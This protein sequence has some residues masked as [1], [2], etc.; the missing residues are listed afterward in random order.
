MPNKHVTAT[1]PS[2][3]PLG[4]CH[5]LRLPRELRNSI[6]HE[7]WKHTPLVDATVKQDLSLVLLYQTKWD[8][9]TEFQAPPA[10]LRTSKMYLSEGLEELHSGS[11]W[12]LR[13]NFSRRSFRFSYRIP[14]NTALLGPS[15]S[16]TLVIRTGLVGAQSSRTPHIFEMTRGNKARIGSALQTPRLVDKLHT[17]RVEIS[18]SDMRRGIRWTAKQLG[19]MRECLDL[20]VLAQSE[21]HLHHFEIQLTNFNDLKRLNIEPGSLNSSLHLEEL[22]ADE[23]KEIGKKVIRDDGSLSIQRSRSGRTVSYLYKSCKRS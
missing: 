17:L 4:A 14:F 16:G 11:I 19:R 7:L 5:F 6:Y 20:S 9:P 12:L 3:T 21:L 1:T 8:W 10:W 23:I 13:C 15:T 22:I 2:I 18:F